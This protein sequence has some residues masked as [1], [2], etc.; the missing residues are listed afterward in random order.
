ME[1][2][3]QKTPQT[4]Y[5]LNFE[6]VPDSCWYSNLRTLLKPSMWDV[7]RRKAYAESGGKCVICGAKPKR[8]E[9]H[10]QWEYD[11]INKIQRLNRVIALCHSCHQVIHIGYAQLNGKEE[12]AAKHFMRVNKCSYVEYRRALGKANEDHARRNKIDEWQLDIRW[13]EKFLSED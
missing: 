6:L 3:E 5:K 11:E 4:S 2:P 1:K 13:L 7:I 10:E 9:A 12:I 8:L